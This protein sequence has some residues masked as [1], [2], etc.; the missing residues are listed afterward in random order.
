MDEPGT[1]RAPVPPISMGAVIP[2]AVLDPSSAEVY[3]NSFQSSTAYGTPTFASAMG[4]RHVVS[5][6]GHSEE[7]EEI[8]EEPRQRHF[9]RS[10]L[11]V[12][13]FSRT[14]AS[15]CC[16]QALSTLRRRHA[17]ELGSFS[18]S[19]LLSAVRAGRTVQ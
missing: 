2:K 17:T 4:L 3:C 9:G 8:D 12:A 11:L 14:L 15:H 16:R 13:D 6:G 1:V 5:G 10:R 18:P 7:L 19:A